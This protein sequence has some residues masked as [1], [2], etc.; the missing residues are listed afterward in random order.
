M[1]IYCPKDT[2]LHIGFLCIPIIPTELKKDYLA[3]VLFI[4]LVEINVEEKLF[5]EVLAC[6]LILVFL[7]CGGYDSL[8]CIRKYII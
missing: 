5:Y 7:I 2:K 1:V 6:F 3:I 4:D 8:L